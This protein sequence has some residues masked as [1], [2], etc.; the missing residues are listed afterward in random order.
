MLNS[1]SFN[2]LKRAFANFYR[3]APA[4]QNAILCLMI[5]QNLSAGIG[6]LFIIPLLHLIGIQLGSAGDVGLS[7][8]IRRFV[9][10]EG[11]EL[12]LWQV[13]VVYILLISSIATIRYL[14]TVNTVS[15]QQSYI[16]YLRLRLYQQLVNSHWQFLVSCKMS[17]FI[18]GLTGQ[19]Q[20]LGHTSN[21][22]FSLIS[23]LVTGVSIVVFAL[24]LSWQMSML[25]LAF[26]LVLVGV[27]LPLN[28]L[29]FQ[30][31]HKE[32]M[33][34]KAIFQMLSEQLMNIKIIK[35]FGREAYFSEQLST[36]SSQLEDQRLHVTK[37][38][39]LSQW[40]YLVLSVVIL[41]VFFYTSFNLIEVP[42]S[43]ILLILIVFS[44]FM[45]L[46]SAMQKNV[47][48]LL[49]SVPAIEDVYRIEKALRAV[50]EEAK[51]EEASLYFERCLKLSSVS[52][53]HPGK[54]KPTIDNFSVTVEKN[55]TL[56]LM[57]ESGVGKSTLADILAGLLM[58]SSGYLYC[59]DQPITTINQSL[60]RNNV[61]YV[62]QDTFLFH[63]SLRTNLSWVVPEVTDEEIWQV[64]KITA[65]D[66]FVAAL[67]LGLDTII[68]DRGITISGG[69]RQRL[70]LARALL[71]KP[72]LLILDEATSALDEMNEK[73]IQ[74]ALDHIHGR[75]TIVI[76]AHNKATLAHA[77]QRV[78][79]Y[80][81]G[82]RIE[83]RSCKLL[84]GER[85]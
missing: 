9:R 8:S 59:D 57:G 71:T 83:Q 56:A 45:P 7:D 48:Q 84:P 75:L 17:D 70:A 58:P 25:A 27:L 69:E 20:T 46:L 26:S 61:A 19:I 14:L 82:Y 64:L 3:F 10:D 16:K 49:H 35:S 63:D 32:L 80:E 55:Q 73:K 24:A 52:Y 60:W 28:R 76:I 31:G 72:Q 42:L 33:G 38:H 53:T 36:V 81:N 66:Q 85:V 34:F 22:M 6:L 5:L 4:K 47:Q 54:N 37:I 2:T 29:I 67:P 62:T 51:Q 41:S 18:H 43:S 11:I 77:D 79:L 68:G 40:S 12:S 50:Q 65:L 44:R 78:I 39:A 30:S 13:L 21:L 1:S 23:Q 15:L 74:Q